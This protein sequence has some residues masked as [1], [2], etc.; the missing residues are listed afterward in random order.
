M[1]KDFGCNF[2]G[3]ESRHRKRKKV[4]ALQQKQYSCSTREFFF[5]SECYHVRTSVPQLINEH[6]ES[7]E[8]NTINRPMAWEHE[9]FRFF[10]K[11]FP[12]TLGLVGS[13]NM[14]TF[15]HKVKCYDACYNS[16]VIWQH[17]TTVRCYDACYDTGLPLLVLGFSSLRELKTSPETRYR[18]PHEPGTQPESCKKNGP[19]ISKPLSQQASYA[20]LSTR[21]FTQYDFLV[22]PLSNRRRLG[23]SAMWRV[24]Q[25][26]HMLIRPWNEQQEN[27]E[28]GASEQCGQRHENHAMWQPLIMHLLSPW[29]RCHGKGDGFQWPWGWPFH[30]YGTCGAPK[31][32]NRHTIKPV[33][34]VVELFVRQCASWAQEFYHK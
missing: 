27:F 12:T 19:L 23:E 18:K 33:G 1:Y 17:A 11:L 34:A 13:A 4:Q 16:Q 21:H 14:K 8:Y 10:E 28:W 30:K 24:L 6:R 22:S 32:E 7:S 5:F 25:E 15:P 31:N 3:A 2:S 20:Y 29:H 9:N 26:R